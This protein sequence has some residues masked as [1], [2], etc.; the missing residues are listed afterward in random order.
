MDLK[1]IIEKLE[2]GR[3]DILKVI[4]RNPKDEEAKSILTTLDMAIEV[5]E[6]EELTPKKTIKADGFIEIEI[7]DYRF[8]RD[9]R[10]DKGIAVYQVD[11]DGLYEYIDNI[12]LCKEYLE[13][14]NDIES[15][16]KVAIKWYTEGLDNEI[17]N[18]NKTLNQI[19]E[20]VELEAIEEEERL[21]KSKEM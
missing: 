8:R 14:I 16:K 10:S 7:E 5:F 11:V 18:G 2:T 15:L 17:K 1:Q 21:I 3:V 13:S 20:E 19:R 6:K 12:K 9:E 4:S